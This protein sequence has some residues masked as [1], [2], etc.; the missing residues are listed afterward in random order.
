MQFIRH[1]NKT[2][3]T[4][5]IRQTIHGDN[6]GHRRICFKCIRCISQ[7]SFDLRLSVFCCVTKTT[8]TSIIFLDY[9]RFPVFLT[10]HF[11]C[12]QQTRKNNMTLVLRSA[13]Q[14]DTPLFRFVN[15]FFAYSFFYFSF[16]YGFFP[17]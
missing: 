16:V 10:D 4:K 12:V 17:R 5:L 13:S 6:S 2:K 14:A 7:F 8:C 11:Y 9:S 15:L 1:R 3:I